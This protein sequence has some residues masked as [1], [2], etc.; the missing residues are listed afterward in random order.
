MFVVVRG[1]YLYYKNVERNVRSFRTGEQCFVL[2]I[3]V[4]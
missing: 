3:S 4:S 2:H 1:A